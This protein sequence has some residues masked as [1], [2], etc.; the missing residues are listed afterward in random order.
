MRPRI[1]PGTGISDGDVLSVDSGTWDGVPDS[2]QPTGFAY[3][4]QWERCDGATC[5]AISGATG[6]SYTATAAD[7]GRSL[8]VTVTATGPTGT[9][10]VP[11]HRAESSPRGR[12]SPPIRRR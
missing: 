9:G 5:P 6:T 1:T 11:T 4:Y 10:T 8:R 2:G 12:R 3:N 7:A